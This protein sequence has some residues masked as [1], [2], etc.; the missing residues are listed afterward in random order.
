MRSIPSRREL[1]F[2]VAFIVSF[3]LLLKFALGS[4]E[5][6]YD[7]GYTWSRKAA[8]PGLGDESSTPGVETPEDERGSWPSPQPPPS[9]PEASRDAR[10][11]ML[12]WGTGKVPTTEIRAHVPGKCFH[13]TYRQDDDHAPGWTIFDR[14]YLLNGTV[15]VVTDEPKSIPDRMLLTSSGFPIVNGP[16]GVANRTPTDNDMQIISPE[17]AS[18]LFG[19][20]ASRIDGASVSDGKSVVWMFSSNAH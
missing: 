16:E 7:S 14:L 18:Q 10:G 20:F 8:S 12:V 13:C 1:I 9:L 2:A 19:S 17:R 6:G 4:T 11:S 5:T 15:F 3:V